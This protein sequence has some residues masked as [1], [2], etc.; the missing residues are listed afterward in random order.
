[1]SS[2]PAT[3]CRFH[4]PLPLNSMRS[5]TR[6][7]AA[8]KEAKEEE[9]REGE[10]LIEAS[11]VGGGGAFSITYDANAYYD[12]NHKGVVTEEFVYRE[13]TASGFKPVD[14]TI[15][16]W[17]ESIMY[18]EADPFKGLNRVLNKECVVYDKKYELTNI[19]VQPKGARHPKI[20]K[21]VYY[22]EELLKCKHRDMPYWA[23]RIFVNEYDSTG[24]LIGGNAYVM[25]SKERPVFRKELKVDI[26]NFQKFRNS[27]MGMP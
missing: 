12:E 24:R 27:L 14:T 10:R 1:M 22:D 4:K 18:G 9:I 2:S 7:A 8:C 3:S 21:R 16:K 25:I 6:S 20:L 19:K 5:F 15:R 11:I 17:S 23:V 13:P 26:D